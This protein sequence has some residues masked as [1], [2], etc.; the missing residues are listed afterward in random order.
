MKTAPLP[1]VAPRLA[2]EKRRAADL[3][4]PNPVSIR[5]SATVVKGTK[6]QANPMPCQSS[7]WTICAVPVESVKWLIITEPMVK[8]TTPMAIIRRGETLL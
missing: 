5:E 6:R 8:A 7:E 3:M 1:E 2:L 4:T